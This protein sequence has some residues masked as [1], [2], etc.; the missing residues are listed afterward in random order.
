MGYPADQTDQSQLI[1]ADRDAAYAE[2]CKRVEALTKELEAAN[3]ELEEFSYSVSH[4]LRAPL[5]RI[6]GFSQAL[7]DEYAEQLDETGQGYLTRV[8]VGAQ[9]MG[10]MIDDLLKF[11]RLTR[12]QLYKDVIDIT[13]LARRIAEEFRQLE[14]GRKVTIEIADGLVAKGDSRLVNVVLT[15]LFDNAWKFSRKKAAAKI[16]LSQEKT[17]QETIFSLS[18]NGAGFD[19]AYA[20]KLFAP[21]QRLHAESEFE[22]TGI[23]LATAKRIVA[24]HGG[25]IWANATPEAGASFFFTLDGSR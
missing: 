19:M 20:G 1:A 22:G 25:R 13:D 24:R 9:K 10:Q 3:Q 16:T 4:D 11:S 23:G 2:V 7:Q 21:F 8:R 12:G 6:D 5:R 14:P 18:D 15:N 17:A